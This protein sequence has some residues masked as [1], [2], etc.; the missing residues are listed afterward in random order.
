MI[1]AENVT[2]SEKTAV[3]V[4]H[5]KLILFG[6]HAVVHGKPAIAIPFPLVGVESIVE[7]VPG[8]IKLDSTFYHGPLESAPT[9]LA[10]I[11]HCIKD[12][13]AYL[14]LPCRDL[15]IQI[16][17]SIPPG[18]GLGSRDRKSTRLNSSHVAISYA[19]FCLK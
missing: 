18:K 11:V 19:V 1:N 2:I 6:K 13:L 5:S 15:L 8:A 17:S 12:T 7:H 10:G 9:S 4:A 16:N 14:E 3:G